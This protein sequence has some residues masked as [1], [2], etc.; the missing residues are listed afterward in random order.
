MNVVVAG[1]I[2][3]SSSL[4][5]FLT[6]VFVGLAGQMGKLTCM[7]LTLRVI[8][9][10]WCVL[11]YDERRTGEIKSCLLPRTRLL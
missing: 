8:K 9:I 1:R 3:F 4:F 11:V 5:P 6:V 10:F 7:Q 2:D